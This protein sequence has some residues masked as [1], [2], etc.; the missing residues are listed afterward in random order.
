M[1]MALAISLISASAIAYEILLM[2]LFS[3][4][5]WHHFA[6]MIISLALLGY[7]ASGTLIALA[8]DRLLPRFETAF[9]C[10]AA[11]FGITSVSGFALAQALPFNPLEMVWDQRQLLHLLLL[12]LV[13]AVPFLCAATCLGLAFSR[14]SQ[15]ITTLYC[16]DLTGAGIGALGIVF[17][18]F[19][20]PPATCLKILSGAGF[21]AAALVFT[22]RRDGRAIA[23]A[24][25]TAGLIL[26]FL[27]PQALTAPH[28]SPYKGLS[29]MLQMPE[30]RV[31]L[32]RSSPLGTLTVVES[33]R[34]PLRYA[35]GRSLLSGNPIP[36]QLGVFTD[37][38]GM[39][40]ITRYDGSHETLAYL[41]SQTAALPFSILKRPK[42]LILGAGGGSDVL[43]ALYHHARQIDAVELN[44][45]MLE[46]VGRDFADHAGN[47]YNLPQVQTHEAEARGFAARSGESYDLIQLSLL[48][49]FTASSAGLHALSESTLYT[50][51]A[52][53]AYFSRLAPGGVLAV[54]RWLKLPPRDTLKLFVTAAQAQEALGIGNPGARMVLI[55]GWNTATLLVK[56]GAFTA[57]EL[58]NI[59][60]FSR[61]R[62][63]DLAYVPGMSATE[64]NR[65]N[66]LA[67]P[68]LFEGARALLGSG[69]EEFIATYK[70]HV[71]PAS[72]DSPYF[73]HFFTWRAL[74]EF[75]ELRGRGGVSLVEW[76][77]VI[78]LATLVQAIAASLLLILLPLKALKRQRKIPA[79]PGARRRT[80]IYFS[81]IG[82]AFL[83]ME[84]SFMQRFAPFLSHPLYA[85]AVVLS[86]F[87]V[88]AGLGSA[89]ARIIVGRFG[90]R[91]PEL[92]VSG[93]V[94]L[95]LAYLFVLPPLF[96]LFM[97]LPQAG[98][99]AVA[100][101]V[102]APLA[103]CMGMPFP[104]GLRQISSQT[105]ELVPW[106]WGIN[107]C[108]SVI[109]AV[110]AAILAIEFGFTVVV[111]AA[112]ALYVLA[113]FSFPV[114][115]QPSRL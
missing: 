64:A 43:R 39:T 24:L 35:P 97:T 100:I 76:S 107:G 46:L 96:E 30:A 11:L 99:V 26:P 42:V 98:R 86:A 37:G 84:I 54:T 52:F 38:G 3:I 69:R 1:P 14:F 33:P 88:F 73:F 28:L 103:F 6:Y 65:H 87:L 70:F 45:Q 74:P 63:F 12:Y 49:S 4:I 57:P 55:R 89:A 90:L 58:E 91:G 110:L 18:M 115:P 21:V 60:T 93:I 66:I 72:D 85:I 56:N 82:L 20:F 61:D 109:S 92:P 62:G 41:D 108:A 48:D 15:R 17:L 31:L 7:G 27:W 40:A 10:A 104:L 2:R 75:L 112:A 23:L 29:Q 51:E 105:P 71:A 78:L 94:V 9:A 101:V 80:A 19:L 25:G 59:R 16:A 95:A 77:Y 102:I 53:R 32:E 106:A 22:E 114:D 47:L 13:L 44:P 79:P 83:F 50:V 111:C 34:V 5:Q 36:P 81:A 8:R 113:A 67:R 68:F